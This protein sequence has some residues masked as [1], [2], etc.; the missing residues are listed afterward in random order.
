MLQIT[1]KVFVCSGKKKQ[2]KNGHDN[3]QGYS[4]YG[5]HTAQSRF[6]GNRRKCH[7]RD[8]GRG[9]R[10]NCVGRL[11]ANFQDAGNDAQALRKL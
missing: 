5:L 3:M 2:H 7:D 11:F 9:G 10:W 4:A 8:H 1:M 6:G